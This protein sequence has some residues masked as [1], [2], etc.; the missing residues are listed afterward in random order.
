MKTKTSDNDKKSLVADV[1]PQHLEGHGMKHIRD[2]VLK[3]I[4][5]SGK[6]LSVCA[7][8]DISLQKSMRELPRTRVQWDKA[9][10]LKNIGFNVN[11]R[12]KAAKFMGDDPVSKIGNKNRRR[13]ITALKTCLSES[14]N[15]VNKEEW[16]RSQVE[17]RFDQLFSHFEG[18]Y[19]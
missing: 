10:L 4:V 11:S 17:Q 8:G 2:S 19:L 13:F 15:G 6:S 3:S 5:Q 7:D 16:P 14:C 12:L 9:H 1:R 18:S